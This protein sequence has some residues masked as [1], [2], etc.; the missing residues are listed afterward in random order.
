[1]YSFNYLSHTLS[2]FS[3]SRVYNIFLSRTVSSL[4]C[5]YAHAAVLCGVWLDPVEF[6]SSKTVCACGEFINGFQIF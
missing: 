2:Q 1:M 6:S 3:P 5:S 4:Q